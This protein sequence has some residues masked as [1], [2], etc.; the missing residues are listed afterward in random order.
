MIKNELI[1][2]F[3]GYKILLYVVAVVVPII[4]YALINNKGLMNGDSYSYINMLFE[5]IVMDYLPFV[6][7][8]ILVDIFNVDY[9]SGSLKFIFVYVNN[10]KKVWFSK[11]IVSC[12][13]MLFVGALSLVAL[14]IVA[15]F[16]P[17]TRNLLSGDYYK[18]VVK[19]A[20]YCVLMIPFMLLISFISYECKN[21]LIVAIGTYILLKL[22]DNVICR[23]YFILPTMLYHGNLYECKY[24]FAFALYGIIFLYL[25]LN[26]FTKKEMIC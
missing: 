22:M 10:R 7:I 21:G 6:L 20:S 26:L 13:L 19:I 3:V 2:S 24:W 9:Y 4:L 17:G 8:I 14:S 12:I 11:F 18:F 23:D 15:F 25:N 1:K 5:N 16:N